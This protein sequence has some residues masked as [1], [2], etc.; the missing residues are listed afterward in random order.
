M[1]DFLLSMNA[2]CVMI[3]LIGFMTT[4]SGFLRDDA[5]AKGCTSASYT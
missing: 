1:T 2:V 3:S 5:R 4:W